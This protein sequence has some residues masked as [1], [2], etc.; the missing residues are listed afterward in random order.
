[1]V[2]AW[3]RDRPDV[4]CLKTIRETLI[5]HMK[6]LYSVFVLVLI[7]GFVWR[8]RRPLQIITEGILTYKE[9]GNRGC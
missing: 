7:I 5:F 1:M 6:L 2:A 4:L 8:R 3:L 9:K